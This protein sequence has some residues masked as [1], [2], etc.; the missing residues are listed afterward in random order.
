M[1][2][3]LLA[4]ACAAV[5]LIT[6][7]AALPATAATRGTATGHNASGRAATGAHLAQHFRSA[8]R[9]ALPGMRRAILAT[10]NRRPDAGA[11]RSAATRA[12]VGIGDSISIIGS[13]C[14]IG[15]AGG[16]SSVGGGG[17]GHAAASG[18]R[19]SQAALA[20]PQPAGDLN[21]DSVG[22]V[23][24]FRLGG[25]RHRFFNAGVT[26]R[27]GSTGQALWSRQILATKNELSFPSA[28]PDLVGADSAPGLILM[29]EV[30]PLPIHNGT[31]PT[32][33]TL[34]AIDGAGTRVWARTLVGQM[35]LTRHGEQLTNFPVPS[36]DLNN[37][38]QPGHNLLVDVIN[39][40]SNF[41]TGEDSG[42]DTPTV[43]SAIDG[44]STALPTTT[45]EA[46]GIPEAFAMPDLDGDGL[47]DV[48]VAD[49][50]AGTVTAERGDDGS[51]IWTSTG[52]AV[53]GG[54]QLA[55]IGDVVGDDGI[56]DLQLAN[57][58]YSGHRFRST[59]S[60]ID[61]ATGQGQW[62]HR[63]LCAYPIA[64]AG[65]PQQPA[66]GLVIGDKSGGGSRSAMA[67]VRLAARYAD[68]SKAFT[69]DL[70][71]TARQHKPARSGSFGLD[72][73]PFGDVQPDGATDLAIRL[74]ARI[75]HHKVHTQGIVSGADGALIVERVGT[76][77]SG[78]LQSGAGDDQVALSRTA[79]GLRLSAYD[80]ASGSRLYTRHVADTGP[81]VL[82]T[83][84]YGLRVTGHACSDLAVSGIS[85]ST[86][87]VGLFDGAGDPLWTITAPSNALR[88]GTV[89]LAPQPAAF[90]VAG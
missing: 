52:V 10:A 54:A 23:I 84:A 26:A 79:H 29:T 3:R 9:R 83:A 61:G 63:G 37:L 12:A 56:T 48:A 41:R 68:G 74:R 57:Q 47:D 66:V 30:I 2:P 28:E 90:C 24:D 43:I 50:G 31:Y 7:G 32:S 27:S 1:K 89:H 65:T 38:D 59:I 86:Q 76:P 5:S 71:V 21:G 20:L 51:A 69:R 25:N 62:T 18:R 19:L 77:T 64:A 81:G 58:T 16:F 33:L 35:K 4:A 40:T 17:V 49:A 82:P 75:G 39:G 36:G 34:T 6:V 67:S 60:L 13:G 55:P 46:G 80:A 53:G 72:L 78:S 70:S 8:Q 42:T 14:F 87:L 44:T 85:R 73:Y 45:A 88:G 11:Q 22:D 15:E